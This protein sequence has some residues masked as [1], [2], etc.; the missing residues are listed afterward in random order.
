MIAFL[1]SIVGTILCR[2]IFMI[3][4]LRSNISTDY[5]FVV[6]SSHS[7]VFLVSSSWFHVWVVVLGI[8]GSCRG[9]NKLVWG[10]DRSV[11]R[12][13]DWKSQDA[14]SSPRGGKAIF[15]PQ[16]NSSADCLT[17]PVQPQCAIACINICVHVKKNKN[18]KH[19]QPYHCLD[20]KI[21]M[22]SAALIAASEPYPGKAT[23]ISRKG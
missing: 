17:V 13:S 4:G 19:W 6:S 3:Q 7:V 2:N 5:G 10:R 8:H 11:G 15:L 18:K 16:S 22:C 12:A 1:W 9:K 20:T 14:S 21:G 23:R